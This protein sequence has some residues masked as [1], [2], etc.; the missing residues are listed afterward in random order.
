M[1]ASWSSRVCDTY[2]LR[3]CC[4]VGFVLEVR[5][6]G[7]IRT[8]ITWKTCVLLVY[9]C[10]LYFMRRFIRYSHTRYWCVR[11]GTAV[12]QDI[13]SR[14]V[15]GKPKAVFFGR[16]LSAFAFAPPTFFVGFPVVEINKNE[17][18]L[19]FSG[20]FFSSPLA[21]NAYLPLHVNPQRA[22]ETDRC[23]RHKNEKPTE[24]RPEAVHNPGHVPPW[25]HIIMS[26]HDTNIIRTYTKSFETLPTWLISPRNRRRNRTRSVRFGFGFS[27]RTDRNRP[28]IRRKNEKSA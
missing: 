23:F 25:H 12:K 14:G 18:R 26:S 24:S 19:S 11:M 9:I 5:T 15:N 17:R 16:F 2:L 27:V 20:R 3:H 7:A 13:R 22:T 8:A 4:F 10:W 6:L 1:F 28:I 21:I